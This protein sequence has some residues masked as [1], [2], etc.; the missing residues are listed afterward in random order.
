MT[1]ISIIGSKP[2]TVLPQSDVA[3]FVNGSI[4]QFTGEVDSFT[5]VIH[6]LNGNNMSSRSKVRRNINT[7]F[8]CGTFIREI[9]HFLDQEFIV[10]NTEENDSL[11]I[12]LEEGVDPDHITL[13]SMDERDRILK[14]ITGLQMPIGIMDTFRQT[15]FLNILRLTY[16]GLF[17]RYLSRSK[18][19][20]SPFFRPSSGV[21]GILFAIHQ[22]GFNPVYE[23][24]GIGFRDRGTYMIN[25]KKK[26]LMDSE[27]RDID[28]HIIPDK[29][30]IKNLLQ[31]D[32]IK[33]KVH[34]EPNASKQYTIKEVMG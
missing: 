34:H 4:M 32:R 10:Y 3:Y 20:H 29:I 21:F 30:V 6:V 25:D 22:H 19:D 12:L 2:D 24:A 27:L 1:C 14:D 7:G 15:S 18:S 16:A 11:D 23:V 28:T 33:L 31:N 13:L 5:R 8:Y 26:K 9:R 17:K